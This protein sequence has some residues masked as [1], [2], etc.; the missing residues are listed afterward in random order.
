MA[1]GSAALR[2]I[3]PD[4]PAV[5]VGMGRWRGGRRV[6]ADAG[7]PA[8]RRGRSRLMPALAVVVPSVNGWD[9]LRGCL[10]ALRADAQSQPTVPVEILVVD[11][12]GARVQS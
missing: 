12:I 8:S 11:R 9:D 2:R 7:S 3:A 10:T 4:V 6:T 5:R 1:Q